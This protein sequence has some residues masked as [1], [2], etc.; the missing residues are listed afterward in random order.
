MIAADPYGFH[1]GLGTT[2]SKVASLC[3]RGVAQFGPGLMVT[4]GRYRPAAT[5]SL[6]RKC[7][8]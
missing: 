8:R 4:V 5:R 3:Q 6:E 7:S 1:G 2:C